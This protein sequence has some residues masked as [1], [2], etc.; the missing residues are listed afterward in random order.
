MGQ[1]QVFGNRLCRAGMQPA[2]ARSVVRRPLQTATAGMM[3]WRGHPAL[4]RGWQLPTGSIPLSPAFPCLHLC[5]PHTR[6][7]PARCHRKAAALCISIPCH[8]LRGIP[9]EP[10][11][12]GAQHHP[13]APSTGSVGHGAAAQ[14]TSPDRNRR[15]QP[16]SEPRN[17]AGERSVCSVHLSA[18]TQVWRSPTDTDASGT[19]T[20][21]GEV[22]D[23]DS[24]CRAP[25]PAASTV[26]LAVSFPLQG[27]HSSARLGV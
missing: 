18:S 9:P 27:T 2:A 15:L 22:T 6:Q 13:N 20:Q 24:M 4:P 23:G 12:A 26:P 10:A 19:R 17:A 8:S 1:E 7:H 11:S 14:L 16:I 25:C 21:R 3:L 5:H